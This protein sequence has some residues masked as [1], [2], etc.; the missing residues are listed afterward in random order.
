MLSKADLP[1]DAEV[2]DTNWAN[3]RGS[4]ADEGE[5]DLSGGGIQYYHL[6][7]TVGFANSEIVYQDGY[8]YYTKMKDVAKDFTL[9]TATWLAS[10]SWGSYTVYGDIA[11]VY[12]DGGHCTASALGDCRRLKGTVAPLCSPTSPGPTA[13]R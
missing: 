10:T 3:G 1:H 8:T 5:Y 12:P 11:E 13:T 2:I 7:D 6:V 9:G 4:K